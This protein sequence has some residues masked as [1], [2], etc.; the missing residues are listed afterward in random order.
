ME[1]IEGV[2]LRTFIEQLVSIPNEGESL[3]S[4]LKNIR[5]GEVLAPALRFDDRTVTYTPQPTDVGQKTN[6]GAPTPQARRLLERPAYIRHC[7]VFVRQL[8]LALAHAHERGIVHRDIKPDN[9]LVDRKLQAH[10]IDFGLARFFEDGTVTRTGSLIGTPRYMSPEQATG[11]LKLDHRTDI[12]SLGLVFYELLSG[13][14]P[15]AGSTPEDVLR[16]IATK[17]LV[18][19][20]WYNRGVPRNLEGIAHRATAKDP[21]ER[22]QTAQEFEE[23]LERFLTGKHV[24]ARTYRYRFDEREI[25][26]ERPSSVTFTAFLLFFYAIFLSLA[27]VFTAYAYYWQLVLLGDRGPSWGLLFLSN[28]SSL[29]LLIAA[30]AGCFWV[31][32]GLLSGRRRARWM[33]LMAVVT[34]LILLL[35]HA[36]GLFGVFSG[37]REDA[38]LSSVPFIFVTVL[39]APLLL[40]RRARDW[41]RLADRLRAE[42]KRQVMPR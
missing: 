12:Y 19:V 13:R 11:R 5:P 22:Y 9:I 33:G 2:S 16:Q 17:A 34:I 37:R 8:A 24:E 4:V 18:P 20:S 32:G 25:I 21:D 1:Y 3:D 31:A 36:I 35:S 41:F 23:D 42:F 28:I 39:Y 15:I 26:A 30:T 14:P 40:S 10:V 6:L 27:T 29:A 7:C 38:V